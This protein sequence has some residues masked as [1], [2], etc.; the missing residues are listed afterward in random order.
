MEIKKRVE[1]LINRDYIERD[2]DDPNTALGRLVEIISARKKEAPHAF[3]RARPC[4]LQ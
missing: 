3:P 2:K 4:L 1:S